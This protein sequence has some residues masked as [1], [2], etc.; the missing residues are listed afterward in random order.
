[1]FKTAK[2]LTHK[3]SV[4]VAEVGTLVHRMVDRTVGLRM[5]VGAVEGSNPPVLA[6][7]LQSRQRTKLSISPK[8]DQP[9]GG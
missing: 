8:D 4:V 7:D 2:I 3:L 5:I 6:V 9:C 1:M